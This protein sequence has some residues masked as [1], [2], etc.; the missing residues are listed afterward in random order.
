[1]AAQQPNLTTFLEWAA[2]LGVSDAPHHHPPSTVSSSCLGHSLSISD[3][4][5]AGGYFFLLLT[6]FFSFPTFFLEVSVWFF[7]CRRG[8]AAVRDLKKGE[9]I[10]RVPK[11][12]LMTVESVLEKDQKLAHCV[13]S[14]DYLSSTQVCVF[15]SLIIGFLITGIQKCLNLR[16]N[17]CYYVC[18]CIYNLRVGWK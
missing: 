16:W 18:N 8:L 13:Q 4:P 1:M 12:V 15:S 3:F 14:H 10:L 7:N 2:Q 17:L 5:E 11:S 9:M 6:L